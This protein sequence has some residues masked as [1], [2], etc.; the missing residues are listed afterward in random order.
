MIFLFILKES[1]AALWANKLRSFL[2]LLGMVMGVTSV[3]AIVST[4]EGMQGSIEDTLSTMGPNTF[5][6]TRFGVGLT[7]EQ[8]LERLKRKK[9]TRNLIPAIEE[10]CD[11]CEHIGAEGYAS[12]HL[13]YGTAKMRWV[14]ITGQTS[15]ALEIQDTD[16]ADGRFISGEDDR[17]RR[18]VAFIGDIV[19][20]TLFGDADPIGER[21]RVGKREFTVIGVAEKVGGMFGDDMDEFV[22]IPLSTLQILFPRPGN[23]VNLLISSTTLALQP[24]AMDQVRVVLRSVR[25]LT[26]EEEDDFGMVTP[27]AI[28]SFINDFTAAFRTIMIALPALSVIIGG[29]VIMNIMMISVTE[30]TREIGIRKALG[31]RRKHILVQFLY[32]SLALSLLGGALG[33][34]LGA[35]AGSTILSSLMDIEIAPT[36][37]AIVLG[38][39][40]SLGVGLFFG[41]YPAMKAARLDPIKA[42]GYE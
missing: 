25:K 1:F 6:V 33:I 2:T 30:R 32:E 39:S 42:L 41:I 38:I 28:L 27:D 18:Q 26:Y 10:G 15:N 19:R 11:D 24:Q 36:T 12:A 16:V 34:A 40:I 14:S 37:V 29:I 5:M 31:A 17:R 22:I 9:L 23:P 8:Y 3:I 20:E 4:V 13:K 21:I 35:W 7:M